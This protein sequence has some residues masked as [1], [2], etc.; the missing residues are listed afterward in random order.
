MNILNALRNLFGRK[1]KTTTMPVKV[2]E[3]RMRDLSGELHAE[4]YEKLNRM[5]DS[6]NKNRRS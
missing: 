5:L 1:P 2:V 6:I 3:R 4:E